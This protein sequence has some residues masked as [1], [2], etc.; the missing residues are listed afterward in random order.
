MT[1]EEGYVVWYSEAIRC[2]TNSR[3]NATPMSTETEAA[4][5]PCSSKVRRHLISTGI[6]VKWNNYP[7]ETCILCREIAVHRFLLVGILLRTFYGA[8]APSQGVH[9]AC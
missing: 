8:E 5:V 7:R 1:L 3:V 6:C 9:L 2:E 4:V